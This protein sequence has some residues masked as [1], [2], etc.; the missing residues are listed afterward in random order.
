MFTHIVHT[1]IWSIFTILAILIQAIP[2]VAV[3]LLVSGTEQ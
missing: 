3:L 1:D 2:A